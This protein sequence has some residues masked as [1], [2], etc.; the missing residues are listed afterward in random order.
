MISVE[1]VVNLITGSGVFVSS[2]KALAAGGPGSLLIGT[3]LASSIMY[4]GLSSLSKMTAERTSLVSFI[5]FV[6]EYI[7][8]QW[9][10]TL[11]WAYV[12]QWLLVLPTELAG[13]SLIAQTWEPKLRR[14]IW[15]AIALV[16]LVYATRN[17]TRRYAHLLLIFLCIQVG[18]MIAL[19]LVTYRQ[20]V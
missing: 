7:G 10:S 20:L 1:E 15:V 9:A 13:I 18:G 3:L 12:F 16:F 11:G 8:P 2:G 4:C 19:R 14:E 5:S 6:A 17:N